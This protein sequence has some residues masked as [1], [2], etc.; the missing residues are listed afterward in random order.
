MELPQY[1]KTNLFCYDY[2]IAH[3]ALPR[4]LDAV[5]DLAI[6]L[7]CLSFIHCENFICYDNFT[8]ALQNIKYLQK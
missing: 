7:K 5:H 8:L 6:Y 1:N 4:I 3:V 2:C